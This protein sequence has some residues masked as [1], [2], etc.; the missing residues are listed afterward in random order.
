MD[1]ASTP[2]QLKK[3]EAIHIHWEQLSL[4]QQLRH[5]NL[6]LSLVTH[7]HVSL[8]LCHIFNLISILSTYYKFNFVFTPF[9]T[10]DNSWAV[11]ICFLKA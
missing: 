8:L 6:N 3:M 2:L 4:K 7:C 11:E 1:H 5:V 9:Q 10:E